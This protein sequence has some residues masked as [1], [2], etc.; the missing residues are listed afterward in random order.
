V[1]ES[2]G[3]AK[4][5]EAEAEKESMYITPQTLTALSASLAG[6]LLTLYIMRRRVR[7]GTRVGKF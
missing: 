5:R 1:A 4:V 6:I 2:H 7:N 3:A